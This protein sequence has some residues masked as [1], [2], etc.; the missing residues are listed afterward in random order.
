M[1]RF[2]S[3][4]DLELLAV[5]FVILALTATAFELWIAT[6]IFSCATIGAAAASLYRSR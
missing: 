3:D 4:N 5:V 1:K 6:I 2:L